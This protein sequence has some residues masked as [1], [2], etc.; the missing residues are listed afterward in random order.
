MAMLP[1]LKKYH[2]L[3]TKLA[4]NVEK[5]PFKGGFFM[6]VKIFIKKKHFR[7]ALIK[8]INLK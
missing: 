4:Q 8:T 2:V 7:L 1:G 3:R 6:L 5:K